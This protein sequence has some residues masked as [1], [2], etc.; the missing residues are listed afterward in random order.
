M[1]TDAMHFV[2]DDADRPA[3]ETMASRF[4]ATGARP[5][6]LDRLT[7]LSA[8]AGEF[9]GLKETCAGAQGRLHRVPNATD[10][11]ADMVRA[12]DIFPE[13]GVFIETRHTHGTPSVKEAT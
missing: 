7:P 1:Q 3:F 13:N 9:P 2:P 8:D 12:A 11:H 4:H 10:Q 5:R 6:R